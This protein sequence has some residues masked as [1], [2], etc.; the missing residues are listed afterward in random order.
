MEFYFD[1]EQIA[2]EQ[3]DTRCYYVTF[4]HNGELLQIPNECGNQTKCSFDDFQSLI[5]SISFS[6][7]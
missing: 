6:S 5:E 1:D 3:N 4:E 7:G 2:C